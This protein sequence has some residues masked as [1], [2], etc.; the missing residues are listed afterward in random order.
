MVYQSIRKGWIPVDQALGHGLEEGWAS[1]PRTRNGSSI[2]GFTVFE[3]LHT[4]DLLEAR[5][6]KI[7][8]NR[9]VYVEGGRD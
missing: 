7:D 5:R 6:V 4:Q 1:V 3:S 9:S 2:T 8:D